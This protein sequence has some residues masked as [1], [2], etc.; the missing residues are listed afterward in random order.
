MKNLY[1]YTFIAC[2]IFYVISLIWP[3]I[4][5]YVGYYY[6]FRCS[7]VTDSDFV[8]I[9]FF[10]SHG[11]PYLSNITFVLQNILFL[12][13]FIGMLALKEGRSIAIVGG[14][15]VLV[16]FAINVL[17]VLSNLQV[18]KIGNLYAADAP[19]S[20][21]LM[22]DFDSYNTILYICNL[23]YTLIMLAVII[24]FLIRYRNKKLHCIMVGIVLVIF[25]LL[26]ASVYLMPFLSHLMSSEHYIL[27]MTKI[28]DILPYISFVNYSIL[29]LSLS[30]VFKQK[31]E[32]E[33]MY[34]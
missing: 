24:M 8:T 3:I 5:E 31:A 7:H 27:L 20:Y 1:K 34:I 23:L 9:D 2:V 25:V 33:V 30:L 18:A 12:G 13:L 16:G 11:S 17:S 14:V 15:G 26:N 29:M 10:E 22:N 28:H 32:Q 19:I 21:S 6:S 4:G